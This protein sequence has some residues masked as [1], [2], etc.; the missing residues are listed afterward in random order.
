MSFS[1]KYLLFSSGV[2]FFFGWAKFRVSIITVGRNTLAKQKKI[3]LENSDEAK[4]S[5]KG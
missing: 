5:G 2:G 1:P 3:Y 4:I